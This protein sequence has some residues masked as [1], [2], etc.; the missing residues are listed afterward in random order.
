MSGCGARNFVR[1][2]SKFRP[3]PLLIA[4]LLCHRQRSQTSPLRYLSKYVNLPKENNF[5]ISLCGFKK[6]F[7]EIEQ[8][9]YTIPRS[10]KQGFFEI[11][12]LFF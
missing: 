7:I 4:R 1:I 9:H 8:K 2:G 5:D 6:L 12:F 3:L 10:K 11:S